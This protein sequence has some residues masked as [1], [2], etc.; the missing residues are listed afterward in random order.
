MQIKTAYI[1]NVY[2]LTQNEPKTAG[3]K[4][5][6]KNILI[7][8]PSS[9]IYALLQGHTTLYHNNYLLYPAIIKNLFLTL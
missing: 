9:Y 2:T 1:D 5:I 7:P 3:I 8:Y 4:D 6:A